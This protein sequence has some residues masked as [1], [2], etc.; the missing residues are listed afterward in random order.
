MS[1]ED[2]LAESRMFSVANWMIG[3]GS[4]SPRGLMWWVIPVAI[5]Q[6]AWPR[7]S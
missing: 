5:G 3:Q 4:M 7:S 1:L 2:A 6:S